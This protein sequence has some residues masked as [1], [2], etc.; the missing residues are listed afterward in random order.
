MNVLP[1]ELFDLI[2][3]NLSYDERVNCVLVCKDWKKK[4][5]NLRL[6]SLIVCDRFEG[7]IT[8]RWF[9]TN[10]A[11][12]RQHVLLNSKFNLLTCETS[13]KI[14]YNVKELAIYNLNLKNG[15][16]N[17]EKVLNSF[18]S[19]ERLDL[20]EIQDLEDKT[21]ICMPNLEVICIDCVNTRLIIDSNK[22][23]KI[24]YFQNDLDKELYSLIL[25][26]P[27]TVEEVEFNDDLINCLTQ[28][29]NLK[30]LY[31]E[32]MGELDEYFL[33]NF[34]QL[35]EIQINNCS[36][37]NQIK[38]L[39]EQK[40][41]FEM[42]ECKISYFSFNLDECIEDK[43][44]E[45]FEDYRGYFCLNE[46]QINFFIQHMSA[47]SDRLPFINELNFNEI[48][49]V[50]PRLP[51][52]FYDKLTNL[53]AIYLNDKIKDETQ[54]ISFI[55]KCKSFPNLTLD[56]CYL[57]QTFFDQLPIHCWF[58]Q[59]LILGENVCKNDKLELNFILDLKYLNTLK[60]KQ[61]IDQSFI[62]KIYQNLKSLKTFFFVLEGFEQT[63]K[64]STNG[65]KY[66]KIYLHQC[67]GTRSFS[68]IK[69]LIEFLD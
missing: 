68:H 65:T 48:I 29:K 4:I 8:Q 18:K 61:E 62:K 12:N 34:K 26:N 15:S 6:R 22:L 23:R 45:C 33:S 67:S 5:L 32:T 2:I 55:E 30:Y 17:F 24:K 63:I 37:Q 25:I 43:L 51:N 58:I 1:I 44:F 56:F 52:E 46:D 21:K 66:Y 50:F 27:E 59:I 16:S 49:N 36:N 39:K 3:N 57:T 13:S 31:L 28:F 54:F 35:K 14:L 41:K 7:L 47:L 10:K 38:I 11:I 60:I 53:Y 42:D 64:Y 9:D 69:D 19:V 20:Y 40:K